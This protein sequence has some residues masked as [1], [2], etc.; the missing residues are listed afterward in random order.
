MTNAARFD[1]RNSFDYLE[2]KLGE[3]VIKTD[4]IISLPKIIMVV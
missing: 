4:I 1:V 3:T 2:P